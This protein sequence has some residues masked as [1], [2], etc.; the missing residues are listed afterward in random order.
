MFIFKLGLF[1]W[2]NNKQQVLRLVFTILLLQWYGTCYF[3]WKHL[4][5]LQGWSINRGTFRQ[6]LSGGKFVLGEAFSHVEKASLLGAVLSTVV[7]RQFALANQLHL[8]RHQLGFS[9]QQW[10]QH[11]QRDLTADSSFV[12]TTVPSLHVVVGA[13]SLHKPAPVAG[14]SGGA[15]D[16]VDINVGYQILNRLRRSFCLGFQHCECRTDALVG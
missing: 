5:S 10:H 8:D 12:Q 1:K 3:S 7:A 6:Q 2:N 13:H 9:M 16:P 4:S 14:G 11:I 15:T